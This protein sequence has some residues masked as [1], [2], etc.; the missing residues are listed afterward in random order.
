[1]FV[2]YTMHTPMKDTQALA[3]ISSTNNKIII[4]FTS[5]VK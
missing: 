2:N 3:F 1:M 5:K 4:L